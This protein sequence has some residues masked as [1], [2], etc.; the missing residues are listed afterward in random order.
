MFA[1]DK[2]IAAAI[3]GRVGAERWIREVL[4]TLRGFPPIDARH[5]GRPV[6]MVV[7]FYERYLGLAEEHASRGASGEE[8]L[9]VWKRKKKAA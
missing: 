2:D 7:K 1:A 4:P 8:N 3:V 5:G 6:A 9:D